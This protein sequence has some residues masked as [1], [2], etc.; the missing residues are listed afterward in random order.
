M[1]FSVKIKTVGISG[2][3]KASVETKLICGSS[4]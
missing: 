4:W 2:D 1:R 3:I